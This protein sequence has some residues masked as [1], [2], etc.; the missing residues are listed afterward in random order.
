[1]SDALAA[2][3][4]VV[5]EVTSGYCLIHA[6]RKVYELRE[7][8]PAQCS[9]VLD[10]VSKVYEYEAETAGM[11][12]RERLAYHQADS[13]PVM[14][15]LKEWIEA[16]MV[17]RLVEPNSSLGHALQYWLNHWEELTLWLREAGAPL[18]ANGAERALKQV[19]LMRKNSLF[20]K[21]EHG[22]TVGGILGSRI[23]TCRLSGA[24]AWDYLA[25]IIRTKSDARRNPQSFLPWNYKP[26][27]A[28]A[29]VA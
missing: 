23:Q 26:A 12:P 21:T 25:W 28:A 9:V 8:Y 18:D 17:E 24:N 7:D 1:M 16:Q 14:K 13:R 15:E 19:I 4:S 22:A 2:N 5:E 29:Q 20:F 3:T 11:S 10:V 6:R 27:E